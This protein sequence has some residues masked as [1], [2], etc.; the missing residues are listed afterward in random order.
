[1]TFHFPVYSMVHDLFRIKFA[2]CWSC[3]PLPVDN[4]GRF[5][6]SSISVTW[7]WEKWVLN[8]YLFNIILIYS[9]NL[10]YLLIII[11]PNAFS[12]SAV[13]LHNEFL[14]SILARCHALIAAPGLYE[15]HFYLFENLSLT[16]SKM[17]L[18]SFHLKFYDM[19]LC[20]RTQ[21]MQ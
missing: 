19:F 7:S 8:S 12:F 6:Y 18:F 17:V 16:L 9:T 4:K 20:I 10:D 14:L 13:H 5:W 15:K 11:N 1:M 3:I 2:N 21:F